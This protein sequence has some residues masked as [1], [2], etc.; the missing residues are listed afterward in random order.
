M[1]PAHLEDFYRRY[2]DCLNRQ[3]WPNLASFVSEDVEHNGRPLGVSGYRNML[4]GDFERI[5]DLHFKVELLVAN[6]PRLGARLRFDV[7]PKG[8]FLGLAVNGRRVSFTENVFYEMRDG[9]IERVWSVLDKLAIESQLS[10][11][12]TT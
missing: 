5:P 3:D 10:A 9:K 1:S 2:I 4:V 7:T 6:P 11:A 8:E 12:T